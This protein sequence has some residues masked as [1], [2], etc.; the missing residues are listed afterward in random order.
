MARRRL[1]DHYPP[2][3]ALKRTMLRPRAHLAGARRFYAG[4]GL[5][6]FADS[7]RGL[8]EIAG[9]SYLPPGAY[10]QLATFLDQN[11]APSVVGFRCTPLPLPSEPMPELAL[12]PLQRFITSARFT[13]HQAFIDQ[14]REITL[15]AAD[16]TTAP[17]W[18]WEAVL[19]YEHYY[20]LDGGQRIPE[21]ASLRLYVRAHDDEVDVAIV[22][23]QQ[24]DRE[25]AVAWL[26]K[27]I[28]GKWLPQPIVLPT[29]D[30]E[31]LQ[32]IRSICGTFGIRLGGMR[33]PDVYPSSTA[34]QPRTG[35]LKVLKRAP[36]ETTPT[37]LDTIVE[38][39]DSD[40]GILGSFTATLWERG[41][42]A[43]ANIEVRQRPTESYTRITWKSGRAHDGSELDLTDRWWENASPVD[44]STERK[45]LYLLRVWQDVLAGID[46][47]SSSAA[48][49]AT[50]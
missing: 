2:L 5:I 18:E 33:S 10:R 44:W 4:E 50:A 48:T 1:T 6:V 19:Q 40:A 39:M 35:F 32:T 16:T 20:T 14:G 47:A 27:V 11:V 12:T 38:R 30:P 41:Q 25:V 49:A 43:V 28:A 36:Y 22:V 13:L 23:A 21:E 8:A 15:R 17:G 9:E 24:Q 3:D 29:R 45:E 37:D 31:R 7:K 26:H 34:E 46:A 42:K